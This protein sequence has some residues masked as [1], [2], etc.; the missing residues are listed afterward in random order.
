MTESLK[1]NRYIFMAIRYALVL[2]MI[3]AIILFIGRRSESSASFSD[4]KDAVSKVADTAHM[5]LNSERFLK[6]YFEL[7]AEDY[8]EILI[9]TPIT[10]MDANELVL[11][12]LKDAS[13]GEAVKAAI[14]NRIRSQ[15]D[16]YEGYAPEQVALLDAAIIDDRGNYILYVVGEN[17]EEVDEAFRGAL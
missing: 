16:I 15:L 4:V 17:S 5:E 10:N 14:E 7:N 9:Y 8:E 1:N 11:L 12:K 3:I 13:Q 6:K 2:I